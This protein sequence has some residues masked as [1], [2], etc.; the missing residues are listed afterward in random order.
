ME[1]GYEKAVHIRGNGLFHTYM[2]IYSTSVVHR[3]YKLKQYEILF[4]PQEIRK[5]HLIPPNVGMAV[6]KQD[7]CNA[8]KRINWHKHFGKQYFIISIHGNACIL[9][10]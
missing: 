2:K 7:S 3:E 10:F 5:T 8:S 6:G 9:E 1:K 4:H